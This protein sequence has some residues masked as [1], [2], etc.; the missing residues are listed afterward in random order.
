MFSGSAPTSAEGNLLLR[1]TGKILGSLRL[2]GSA[3][4]LL[5]DVFVVNL[6]YVSIPDVL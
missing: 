5:Q 4:E 2:L 1:R 6:H 3:Y